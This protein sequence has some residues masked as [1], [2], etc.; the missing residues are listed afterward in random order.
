MPVLCLL[1]K[2][3]HFLTVSSAR[4]SCTLWSFSLVF[5]YCLYFVFLQ[6]IHCSGSTAVFGL[7]ISLELRLGGSFS[8]FW[9]GLV[10]CKSLLLVNS[11]RQFR[12][13]LTC[14][15][16]KSC[17][18]VEAC[19]IAL[20]FRITAALYRVAHEAMSLHCARFESKH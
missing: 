16:G 17:S 8:T 14:V 11:A 19:S 5:V 4:N 3:A 12:W 20:W 10:A 1:C 2:D 13:Y 15:S 18:L 7:F 9:E 6:N